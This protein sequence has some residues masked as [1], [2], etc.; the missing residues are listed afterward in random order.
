[1]QQA[2]KTDKPFYVNVWPD[3]VHSPFDPPTE[4]R[5]DG[6][7]HALYNGVVVN[8]DR[9]LAPL[10]DYVRSS[11]KLRNN[12]LIIV[13]SDNGPEPGAGSAG[14]FRGAKGTLYEGGIREP[15]ITWGPGLIPADKKGS[16]DSTTVLS[17][18][19]LMPSLLRVAGVNVPPAAK[20]DGRD[21]SAALLGREK[22]PPATKPIF[23]KRPPDR[24]GP[25]RNRFPDL[26]VRDG[27]W[28]L[29][30]DEDGSAPQLY[31]LAKDPGEARNIAA[32]N[33]AV[34]ERLK[35][36]VLAWNSTL[37]K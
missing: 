10:F 36:A 34:V 22:S 2:E 13:A 28:K 23:W 25:P 33:T 31:D 29:L 18:I 37:P 17:S 7:K 32:A 19:D 20:P 8:M 21:R 5:G 11:E 4:L 3:D 9:Q 15:L 16:V 6:S 27:N 26:A 35:K 14:V 1:I 30:V 24:P 12:T